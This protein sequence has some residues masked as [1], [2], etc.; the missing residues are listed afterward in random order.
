MCRVCEVESLFLAESCRSFKNRGNGLWLLIVSL[1][2][3]WSLS[4]WFVSFPRHCY[5]GVKLAADMEKVRLE[6]GLLGTFLLAGG[7]LVRLQ[8]GCH[9]SGKLFCDGRRQYM[10]NHG[11]GRT[12]A[13]NQ[14]PC[15]HGYKEGSDSGCLLVGFPLRRGAVM[16]LAIAVDVTPAVD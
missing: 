9:P 10:S 4:W 14:R 2:T 6:H 12:M 15:A 1:E 8:R 11:R 5:S 3:H 16:I 13:L 7:G